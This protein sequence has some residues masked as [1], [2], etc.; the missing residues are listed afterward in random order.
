VSGYLNS[1]NQFFESNADLPKGCSEAERKSRIGN[2]TLDEA[3]SYDLI[4]ALSSRFDDIVIA[5]KRRL[6]GGGKE[7]E[8][9][10]SY[11]DVVVRNHY[12][13]K[14]D[15]HC[16]FGLINE[17][18]RTTNYCSDKGDAYIYYGFHDSAVAQNPSNVEMWEE[19]DDDESESYS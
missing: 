16:V 17:V 4:Q 15:V 18:Q 10:R 11:H 19:E 5:G 2:L 12:A 8:S 7:E 13:L 14:G 9:D 1:P 3:S 6:A